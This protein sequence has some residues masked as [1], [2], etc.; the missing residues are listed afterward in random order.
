MTADDQEDGKS[1]LRENV[2]K[3]F[4]ITRKDEV[5]SLEVIGGFAHITALGKR[6]RDAASAIGSGLFS[7]I[8]RLF[9]ALTGKR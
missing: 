8:K 5:G 9:S 1:H 7:K 4:R 6:G 2:D 3:Y